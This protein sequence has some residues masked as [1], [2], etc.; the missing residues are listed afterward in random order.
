M[1]YEPHSTDPK[2]FY[3]VKDIPANSVFEPEFVRAQAKLPQTSVRPPL[4]PLHYLREGWAS[5]SSQ[6]APGIEYL[7][8][9]Q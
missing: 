4:D 3:A 2:L 7:H 1:V 9:R 8:V 6:V 5:L